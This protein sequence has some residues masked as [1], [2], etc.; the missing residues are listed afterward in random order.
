MKILIVTDAWHPQ[1][2][3]VVRSLTEVAGQLGAFG[4]QA[5]FLTPSG[6]ATVG[7]PTYPDIRLALP[8][9]WQVAQRIEAERPDF[10]HIATEGPLGI[11]ARRFC[12]KRRRAFTTSYHTRFPDYVAARL[13]FGK[14]WM[15]RLMHRFHAPARVT[16]VSTPT[17]ERE[18][19]TLGYENLARWPRGVDTVLFNP[20]KARRLDLP[21]PIFLYAGRIAVEKNLEAF[22]SL[23]LPGT[24]MIAGGGPARAELETKYPDAQFCGTLKGE[25]LA[26][27][28][29]SA[30]AFVFPSR[31]DTFGNVMLEA[32][33]SGV[34][35]AA[36]PVP[37]PLDVIG[38]APVG[39]LDHD[40]RKAALKALNIPRA[41]CRNF[42][43][44]FSWAASARMF[45]SNILA[46]NGR[47]PLPETMTAAA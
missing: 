26:E 24:K 13:K 25:Q 18:L 33:A 19:R 16:M 42:A 15:E 8:A 46:A 14:R 28:Y 1:V 39:V 43:L 31:T 9:P 21:R 4:T 6:F 27:T 32:L 23:D 29:A 7:M 35:V 45:L 37:G 2:N 20:R 12:M 22:L 5:V 41:A 34:P 44:Q 36:F 3:G 47:S 10:I 11:L 38:R 40:L 30:D 17:L